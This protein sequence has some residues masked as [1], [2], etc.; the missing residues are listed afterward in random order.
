[1]F[2]NE[3][4]IDVVGGGVVS[5]LVD[6]YGMYDEVYNMEELFGIVVLFLLVVEVFGGSIGFKEFL[7][8]VYIYVVFEEKFEEQVSVSVLVLIFF[9]VVSFELLLYV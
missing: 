9:D 4:W 3:V 1:M 5:D 6:S 2:V 7:G 8:G